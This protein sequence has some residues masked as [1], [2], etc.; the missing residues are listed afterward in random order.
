VPTSGGVNLWEARARLA[1]AEALPVGDLSAF[2]RSAQGRRELVTE[3]PTFQPDVA[4]AERAWVVNTVDQALRAAR[5]PGPDDPEA[6]GLELKK[7]TE[8]L[9][10]SEHFAARRNQVMEARQRLFGARLGKAETALDVLLGRGKY[11]D[12]AGGARALEAALKPEAQELGLV[13]ALEQRVKV[14]RQRAARAHAADAQAVLRRLYD[15]RKYAE[16]PREAGRLEA[17]LRPEAEATG[18]WAE[19]KGRL[20]EVRREALKARL[21]RARGDLE[22]YFARA[23][24]AAVTEGAKKATAELEAEARAAERPA[25]PAEY[26]R[27]VRRR[28]LKEQVANGRR[29]LEELLAGGKLAA[30]AERGA[31]LQAGL[32]GEAGAAGAPAGW[33]DPL[34]VV[35]RQA[36]KARLDLARKEALALLAADRYQ[37]MAAAGKKA[38]E[39]LADEARAVGAH[40]EVEQFNKVCQAYAALAAQA[41]KADPE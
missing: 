14:V 9:S 21:E 41:G 8:Q 35:R 6:A 27:P 12:V 30:V 37:A 17:D 31:K 24:F 10:R 39:E 25:W 15:Q 32:E 13:E 34:L 11:A 29:E 3:F 1:E 4:D 5:E 7:L 26:L 20:L 2:A 18:T 16:V 19:A 22:A 40:A 33:K 23:D 36:L 38:A 28:A